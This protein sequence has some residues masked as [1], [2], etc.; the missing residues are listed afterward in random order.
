MRRFLFFA[1]LVTFI[2]L[3][4]FSCLGLAIGEQNI[5]NPGDALFPLQRFFEQGRL[6]LAANNTVKAHYLLDFAD[7]R[8]TQLTNAVGSPAELPALIALDEA[9][10]LADAAVAQA[11]AADALSLLERLKDVVKRSSAALAAL[12]VAPREAPDT[13]TAA[14]AKID[15]LR[16]LLFGQKFAGNT[17]LSK[18]RTIMYLPLIPAET[19]PP[20]GVTGSLAAGVDPQN[21]QFPSGSLAAQHAFFP[22]VGEHSVLSCEQCHING[23]FAGTASQCAACHANKLPANHFSGDCAACHTSVSWADMHFNHTFAG[24]SDCQACHKRPANHYTGQ[25]S[26]CHNTNAW[27]PANFNHQAAKA[28]GCQSCHN[29]P[30]NHFDGQCS[31]CHKTSAWLPASLIIM[32]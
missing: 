8:I 25:C 1:S 20:L 32:D 31:G 27:R 16:L 18:L 10:G 19:N 3:L 17:K 7:R 2:L 30:V 26:A 22:L 29:R 21:I 13:Y 9:L 6:S 23:Q 28:A 14:Q 24:S 4:S 11:P 5:F 12:Q 15:A